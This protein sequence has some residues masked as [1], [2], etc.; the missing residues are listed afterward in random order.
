MSTYYFIALMN[1]I[2]ILFISFILFHITVFSQDK[3]MVY[4]KDKS[5]STFNPY[6]YFAPKAIQRK[7]HAHISM[8]DSTDFPLNND[9]VTA[10][11]D[12][13]TTTLGTSRWFNAA[14][15]LA[16]EEQIQEIQTLPFV[17]DVEI[18]ASQKRVSSLEIDIHSASD[19][20]KTLNGQTQ[21]LGHPLFKLNDYEG[22][23]MRIAIFDVGFK[24]ANILGELHHIFTA[25]HVIKTYDFVKKE[26]LRFDKGGSH[27]T[28]V[29]SCI[30][31]IYDDTNMG[32]APQ[33]EFL[34]ARTERL[35]TEFGS[36][37]ENWLFAAEWADKNGADIINSSLG[38]T[39]QRYYQHDMQGSTALVT[40]AANFAASKGILVISS[41]GNEGTSLWKTIGAPADADSVLSVGGIEPSLGY[42]SK[43]SSYGPTADKRLKPNV[44]AYGTAAVASKNGVELNSGTSFSSPLIVGFAACAWQA[45]PEYTNMEIFEELEKS[46]TL[47][48]YFDYVHGYGLPQANYFL[49]D[50]N[51]VKDIQPTFSYSLDKNILT[52]TINDSLESP[53]DSMLLA[54]SLVAY[55]NEKRFS[56]PD[57]VYLHVENENGT[58]DKYKI[59]RPKGSKGGSINIK[60]LK[61]KTIRIYY[62]HYIEELYVE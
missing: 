28:M 26:T 5:G 12:I 13:A 42:H 3:Y 7:L 25:N 38:Y 8:A 54:D 24:A 51:I 49:E 1:R 23:G 45:H 6:T 11:H 61:G 41:A 43:W 34:L 14:V 47:Y 59:I 36:E 50:N 35:I 37:E 17:K 60:P 31:G 52:I 9:Y 40:R 27:G 33:A 21:S 30:A 48:P 18:L 57:Y 39:T 44:S 20:A 2:L 53:K 46:A 19:F 15:C 4:F 58:L 56:V 10:I 16:N 55:S 22:Q 62:K 29:L 32:M